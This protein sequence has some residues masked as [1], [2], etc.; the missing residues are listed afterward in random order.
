MASDHEVGAV[1]QPKASHGTHAWH[2]QLHRYWLHWLY[3]LAAGTAVAVQFLVL[4][5]E[6]AEALPSFVSWL[7]LAPQV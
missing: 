5:N 1:A 6:G 3:Q 4:G 2:G 7:T